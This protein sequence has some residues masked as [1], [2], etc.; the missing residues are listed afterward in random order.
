MQALSITF[1]FRSPVVLE[2]DYP[3]HL[4]G[5]LASCVAQEAEEFGSDSAWQDAEDLSH[6]LE[7]T[8]ADE[9]GAWVWKASAFRFTARSERFFTSIVRRCEPEAFMHSMDAGLLNMRRPRNYLSAGTGNERSYFLLHSYQW[10]ESATAWCIGDA[11]EIEQALRRVKYLGKMGRNGFGL[12]DSFSIGPTHEADAW[13][14]RF[15]PANHPGVPGTDYAAAQV[16]LQAPYWKKTGLQ[17]AK[18]PVLI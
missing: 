11:G 15:L 9:T 8:D 1:S 2:S 7:R 12:V 17:S 13:M 5:L 16:R 14:R 10:M 4:D 18:A 6:L 3:L